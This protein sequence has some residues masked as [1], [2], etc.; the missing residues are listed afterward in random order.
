MFKGGVTAVTLHLKGMH[1]TKFSTHI[2]VTNRWVVF[3]CLLHDGSIEKNNNLVSFCVHWCSHC[4]TLRHVRD[5]KNDRVIY[6]F[7]HFCMY[8]SAKVCLGLWDINFPHQMVP[9]NFY[10]REDSST[11]TPNICPS[12]GLQRTITGMTSRPWRL[13]LSLSMPP[14]EYIILVLGRETI[15]VNFLYKGARTWH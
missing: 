8:D 12:C 15:T 5:D 2:L 11:E 4:L 7:N 13:Q 6:N 10:D 9:T 3:F 14:T 1:C